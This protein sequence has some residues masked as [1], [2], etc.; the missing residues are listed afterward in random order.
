MSANFRQRFDMK[1]AFRC[2]TPLPAMHQKQ[3][4]RSV[5]LSQVVGHDTHIH[6]N[7]ILEHA[8]P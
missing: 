7:V 2:R 8:I 3:Q 1:I 4:Q 6:R 5:P